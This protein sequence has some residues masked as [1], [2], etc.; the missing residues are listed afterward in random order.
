MLDFLRLLAP[1][2]GNALRPASLLHRLEQPGAGDFDEA[3][4]SSVVRRAAQQTT[5]VRPERIGAVVESPRASPATQASPPPSN[6]A[7]THAQP[8]RTAAAP[9]VE[10][11]VA[12]SAHRSSPRADLQH[13]PSQRNAA[14]ESDPQQPSITAPLSPASVAL[15]A[16]PATSNPAP[17][18]HVSIDRIEVRTPA[19]ATKPKATKPRMLPTQPLRDYLRGSKGTPA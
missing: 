11:S 8:D 9:K 17:T 3:T 15:H 6:R 12:Q 1:R 10:A 16:A 4:Q 18:I 7:D 2:H 5:S 13:A 14:R 19:P